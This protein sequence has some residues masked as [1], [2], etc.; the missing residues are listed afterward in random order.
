VTLAPAD[1]IY[2]AG[3]RARRGKLLP[4]GFQRV[5]QLEADS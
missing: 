1:L 2:F 4:R 5:D 3:E